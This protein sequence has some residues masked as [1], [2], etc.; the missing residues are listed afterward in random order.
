M[1]NIDIRKSAIA[2]LCLI[3]IMFGSMLVVALL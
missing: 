2:V 1:K 3:A